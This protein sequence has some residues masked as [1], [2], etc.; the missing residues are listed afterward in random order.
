MQAIDIHTHHVK[1]DGNVQVLN[2]FAQDLPLVEP[3]YFFSAGLHPWHIE[4]VNPEECIQKIDRAATQKNM[5]AIG[6]CGLDRSIKVDFAIQ[7]QCFK[8][9]ILI[10]EKHDKP[11]IIHC[12]RAYSDLLKQKKESKSGLPWII[13]GYRGN[14]E[15]T[16]SLIKHEFYFSV[17]EQLLKD[18]SKHEVFHSIP[19]ERLFLETDESE[20]SIAR[21]YSTAAQVLRLDENELTQTIANNFTSV[22]GSGHLHSGFL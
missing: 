21:I 13:H 3:D 11:L 15:T 19:L 5:L 1:E 20:W 7:E 8:Q 9:Q 16:L 14:L 10:A 18:D 22:F 12:V 17:G 4:K 2:V 6:E